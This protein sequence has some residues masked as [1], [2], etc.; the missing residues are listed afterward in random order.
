M[1]N[2]IDLDLDLD[3][4]KNPERQRIDNYT[5][6]PEHIRLGIEPVVQEFPSLD[7]A[8]V[9]QESTF[10]VDDNDELLIGN[11]EFNQV[12]LKKLP[13]SLIEK[14]SSDIIN[15]GEFVLM[16]NNSIVT[17]GD[18]KTILE[19]AKLILYGEHPKYLASSITPD[20]VIVLKRV[21]LKVGVFIDG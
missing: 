7:G 13:P 3:V 18:E 14:E 10:D 2:N 4:I 12:T 20:K 6:V 5:C 8:I 16:V 17:Y 21:N 19:E 9:T 11:N 1:K 15:V